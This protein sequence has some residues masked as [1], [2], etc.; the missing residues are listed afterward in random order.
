[1]QAIPASLRRKLVSV[2][3]CALLTALALSA[4]QAQAYAEFG[5][6]S[7][8][9]AVPGEGGC[10]GADAEGVNPYGGCTPGTFPL[11]IASAFVYGVR[12]QNNF[13]TITADL[14]QARLFGSSWFPSGASNSPGATANFL[15][16]LTVVGALP[17]PVNITV[18]LSIAS[19]VDGPP[20]AAGTPV[21]AWLLDG[22]GLQASYARALDSCYWP[23]QGGA[24]CDLG[25]GQV[26]NTISH[27][28]TV[29]DAHRSFQVAALLGL[30]GAYQLVDATATLSVSLPA[31]LSYTSASGVFPLP[32]VPEPQSWVLLAV[33]LLLMGVRLRRR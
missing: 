14:S 1:M 29:D 22:G 26:L 16:T 31:G 24:L 21:Q 11:S 30:G 27:V 23:Q 4:G 7:G 17:A 19:N 25:Y 5:Y 9:Y 13:A 15:D 3:P 2:L 20:D 10:W 18:T 33:G 28:E 32:A 12:G 6:Y 8:A